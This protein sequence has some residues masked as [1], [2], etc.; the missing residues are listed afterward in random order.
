MMIVEGTFDPIL[1]EEV[2]YLKQLRKIT[3]QEIGLLVKEEG[4]LDQKIRSKLVEKALKPY[5]HLYLL[6]KGTAD[7]ELPDFSAKEK[8][9]REGNFNLIACGAHGMVL[10][11]GLYLEETVDHMCNAHRAIHSRGVAETCVH[12]AHVHHMN[13][14]LA[15]RM[16]MLH[17][18]T[19]KMS[20]EEGRKI[21]ATWKPEWLSI[22]PKV[23]HSYTAVIWMKQ[24]MGIY[25]YHI[26]H[27]IEHH[28]LGDGH[29]DWDA[30]LYISDKI[31]PNRGYD[32]TKEMKC[33]EKN[34]QKGAQMVLNESKQYILKKEGI[35][36]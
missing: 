14:T 9:A 21:I 4:H 36:V 23:W 12:L 20:D 19:K 8:E 7:Q 13:E 22:S 29:S 18:I 28:T 30:V 26:L 34:L 11:K 15:Y 5:R 16:G 10:A 3:G 24:N 17:D 31:E 25:D 27:A 1:K 35:H 33:S 2:T 6:K 32:S